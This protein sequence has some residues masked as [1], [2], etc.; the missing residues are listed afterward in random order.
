[1]RAF[2]AR[3]PAWPPL[4]GVFALAGAVLV[5]VVAPLPALVP[6]AV[7]GLERTTPAMVLLAAA[8][9]AAGIVAVVAVVARL[10]RPVTG[11]QLGL[12]APDALPGAL[13]LTAGAAV[14]LGA[15]AALWSVLGDLR[16]SLD[17]PPE[18]DT[19]SLTAQLYDLPLREPVPLGPGLIASALAGCVLPVVAGEILLR[20]FAFP[21]LAGWNG[22]VPAALIVSVLFGGL[23]SLGGQPGPAVLSMLLGVALCALYVATGSLLPGIALASGASAVALGV[24]CA[25]APAG[26]AGLAAGCAIAATALGGLPARGRL[27]AARRPLLRGSAA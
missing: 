16:G 14:A 24:A 11:E 8:F 10:T 26:I 25:L 4:A 22:P 23:T 17:V 5:A 7:A 6:A 13:L 21:A 3:V 20:G 19:R 1:M 9:S 12:R 15:V 2:G 27:G 18:L